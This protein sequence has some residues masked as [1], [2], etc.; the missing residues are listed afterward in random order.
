VGAIIEMSAAT[1]PWYAELRRES[2]YL[3]VHGEGVRPLIA[4]LDQPWE[5]GRPS[6]GDFTVPS[7]LVPALLAALDEIAIHEATHVDRIGDDPWSVLPTTDGGITI[8]GP[9]YLYGM[10]FLEGAMEDEIT[11]LEISYEHLPQLRAAIGRLAAPSG[12]G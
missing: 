2:F 1:R 5:R 3:N 6:Y 7:A 4:H 10:K 9:A 12:Q 8:G 11:A